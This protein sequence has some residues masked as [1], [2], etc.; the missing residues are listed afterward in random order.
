MY[1]IH[2]HG[3]GHIHSLVGDTANFSSLNSVISGKLPFIVLKALNL[4]IPLIS[5]ILAYS[6]RIVIDT[7]IHTVTLTEH[8]H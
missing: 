8:A 7:Q 6:V 1:D 3:L 2:V 4:L 5:H